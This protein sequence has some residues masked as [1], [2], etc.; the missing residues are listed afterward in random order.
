MLIHGVIDYAIFMLDPD[1]LVT[2]WNPGAERIKGYTEEEILGQHFS[3][4]YLEEDRAAGVPAR[5]LKI[6]GETGRL[7]RSFCRPAK[8]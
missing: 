3:V 7:A 1:G 8:N 6:A 5:A 2:S 4:F